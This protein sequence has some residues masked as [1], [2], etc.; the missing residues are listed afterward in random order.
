MANERRRGAGT[1]YKNHRGTYT[2]EYR[3]DGKRQREHFPTAEAA[4]ARLAEIGRLKAAGQDIAGGR[5]DVTSWLSSW[6]ELRRRQRLA[7]RTIDGYRRTIE[8]YILPRIGSLR[9]ADVR[10][11]HLQELVHSVEDDIS[12]RTNGLFTGGRTIQLM[13][14]VLNQSFELALDRD[15]IGRHPMRGVLLPEYKRGAAEP[16]NDAQVGAIMRAAQASAL[17]ALWHLYM[18]LGLRRS[19]ALG[20]RWNDIDFVSGTVRIAQQVQAVGGDLRLVPPKRGSER[21]LPLVVPLP[22]LLGRQRVFVAQRRLK[23]GA[24]WVDRDLVFPS[25]HGAPLWPST[26]NHWWYELRDGAGL[27]PTMRLHHLR[28][29]VATM[30][31]EADTAEALIGG[32]LGHAKKNVT[33]HYT[34]ARVEAM[35]RALDRVVERVMRQAA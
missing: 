17:P 14:T 5:Q 18:L 32:I 1:V 12:E 22:D 2:A 26:V 20:L 6:L 10:A 30:L 24:S 35:R 7:A 27:P 21:T 34:H 31:V 13:A 9:L 11:H 28:H 8:S 19:E 29:T 15:L 3:I 4:E 33:Q 23:A 25:D 16:A